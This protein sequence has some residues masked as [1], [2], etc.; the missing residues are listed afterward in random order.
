MQRAVCVARAGLRNDGAERLH[1]LGYAANVLGAF[2]LEVC[3]RNGGA[4][5]LHDYRCEKQLL[6]G[7]RF[8]GA[9]EG[10]PLRI[11]D[12]HRVVARRATF[13]SVSKQR[14]SCTRYTT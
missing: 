1:A 7:F 13:C 14:F 9:G 5:R 2:T 12:T 6:R 3:I 4:G 8:A 10:C 11:E